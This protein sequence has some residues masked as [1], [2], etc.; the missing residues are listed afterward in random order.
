KR[1]KIAKQ[2]RK[3]IDPIINAKTNEKSD[4]KRVPQVEAEAGLSKM[5]GPAKLLA[6]ELLK[7][8][9]KHECCQD[10]CPNRDHARAGMI[11]S[12]H[13]AKADLQWECKD[14]ECGNSDQRSGDDHPVQQG[15]PPYQA[16]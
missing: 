7:A 15:R 5:C 6:L 10:Q 3:S 16:P 12:E 2:R 13:L 8:H 9:A 1:D 11:P 4:N 14:Y